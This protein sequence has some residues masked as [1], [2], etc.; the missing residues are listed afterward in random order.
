VIENAS[1]AFALLLFVLSFAPNNAPIDSDGNI[2]DFGEYV[3]SVDRYLPSAIDIFAK[4]FPRDPPNREL[5]ESILLGKCADPEFLTLLERHLQGRTLTPYYF[6]SRVF[7]M[8]ISTIPQEDMR[9][10]P[11]ALELRKPL[12]L[13]ALLVAENLA[14]L[15]P[16]GNDD[17]KQPKGNSEDPKLA[18]KLESTPEEDEV[19]AMVRDLLDRQTNYNVAL[20]WLNAG[21]GFGHLLLRAA[22]ALGSAGAHSVPGRPEEANPFARITQRC[23]WILRT[24]MKKATSHASAGTLPLGI[25]PKLEALI[26]AL[27]AGDMD[28]FVVRQIFAYSEESEP[29]FDKAVAVE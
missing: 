26:G 8:V 14:A 4:V 18:I 13:Q 15:I 1:D 20:Q 2:K 21:N 24:L 23:I 25:S 12:L 3:P 29:H 19:P 11:R 6:L 7:G 22:I 17:D 27:M 16:S 9:L 10:I 5:L 28:K